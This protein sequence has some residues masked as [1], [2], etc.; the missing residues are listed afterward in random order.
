[1]SLANAA[2][3]TVTYGSGG[4]SSGAAA[5][6]TDGTDTFTTSTRVATSTVYGSAS[7]ISS[8]PTVT[9]NTAVAPTGHSFQRKTWYDGSRFWRATLDNTNSRIMFEYS[10]D[11]SS[12]T[13][14][15]SARIS[16]HT[17]DFSIEADGSN[18]FIV[19]TVAMI[20][21]V[22]QLPGYPAT[23]FLGEVSQRYL[24]A[25]VQLMIIVTQL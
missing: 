11:G 22:G 6:S 24:M 8:S 16:V 25:V 17:N 19:Y 18:A 5:P 13:E 9:V 1:M 15:T 21:K 10:S 4:G 14:N 2:T 20:S 3:V 23:D 7:D 12:W